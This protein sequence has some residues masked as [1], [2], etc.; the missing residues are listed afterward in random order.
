MSRPWLI[1][2]VGLPFISV[3]NPVSA[4]A[5]F[6]LLVDAYPARTWKL[7]DHRGIKVMSVTP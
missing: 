7:Y 2:G 5:M 6:R 1:L 3:S 4:F